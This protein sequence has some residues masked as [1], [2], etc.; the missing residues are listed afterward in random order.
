MVFP[1]RSP[2]AADVLLLLRQLRV[3]GFLS[4]FVLTDPGA[5]FCNSTVDRFFRKY[6]I[7][8]TVAAAE[9]HHTNGIN[10][11]RNGS[12][13]SC[14]ERMKSVFPAETEE[15][16]LLEVVAATNEL[17]MATL[18]NFSPFEVQFGKRPNAERLCAE[19]YL[20][21]E[22]DSLEDSVKRKL[23][24]RRAIFCHLPKLCNPGL[25]QGA[26]LHGSLQLC[27]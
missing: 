19:D 9:S 23:A 1:R 3:D 10:E 22:D 11:Q 8:H 4:D 2:T 18:G 17:P 7:T 24:A 12:L 20:D 6:N 14:L 5:E 27:L 26:C 25:H 13:K 15:N 21:V 16:L